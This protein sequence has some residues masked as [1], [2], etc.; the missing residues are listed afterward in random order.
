MYV[1]QDTSRYENE[2]IL[3]KWSSQDQGKNI[4][5][6]KIR[7]TR[8]KYLDFTGGDEMSDE[9]SGGRIDN[10]RVWVKTKI[11][12]SRTPVSLVHTMDDMKHVTLTENLVEQSHC[13][14][15][16]VLK[17]TANNITPNS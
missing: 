9:F 1:L 13:A 16:E 17:G 14:W 2:E 7:N 11:L 5:K 10:V 3:I 6:Y 8:V 4:I 12:K 15:Q